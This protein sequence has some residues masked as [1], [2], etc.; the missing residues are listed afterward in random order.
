[1]STRYGFTVLFTR[2]VALRSLTVAVITAG[3]RDSEE[4]RDSAE[5]PNFVAEH[6]SKGQ[7]EDL[8]RDQ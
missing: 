1:M 4:E 8:D 5:E 6:E 3:A 7:G 2:I